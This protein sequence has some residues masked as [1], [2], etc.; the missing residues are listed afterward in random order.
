M[1]PEEHGE[2][3]QVLR[4]EKTQECAAAGR[5]GAWT[6]L[7]PLDACVCGLAVSS[8]LRA[9]L[10]IKLRQAVFTECQ[11]RNKRRGI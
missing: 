6:A 5:C 3:I 2:A 11:F 1:I 4:Y 10:R 9:S 8:G 7:G